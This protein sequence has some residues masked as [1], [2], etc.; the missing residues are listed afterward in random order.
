MRKAGCHVPDWMLLLKRGRA[1][2]IK[3]CITEKQAF[4]KR[5]RAHKRQI[6]KQSKVRPTPTAPKSLEKRDN[7][8]DARSYARA[9][10]DGHL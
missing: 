9:G 2:P 8:L 6:V 7:Y 3:A 5:A 1:Q 10:D 4:D